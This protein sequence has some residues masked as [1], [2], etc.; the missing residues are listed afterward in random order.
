MRNEILNRE[1]SALMDFD[2]M[3]SPQL[4]SFVNSGET[5]V[6]AFLETYN[7]A[8]S[9]F[10]LSELY[11]RQ[12]GRIEFGSGEADLVAYYNELGETYNQ[13]G[14]E[15]LSLAIADLQEYINS[16]TFPPPGQPA[17]FTEFVAEFKLYFE[18][19]ETKP[20]DTQ[21]L[22]TV[23]NDTVAAV[24]GGEQAT[25]Q[26][27]VD[28]AIELRAVRLSPD[29]GASTN[30]AWWKIVAIAVY[31]GLAATEIWFCILKNKCSK[32]AKAVLKGG[33]TIAALVMKF[34]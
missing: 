16:H 7:D 4:L 30:L 24:S 1:Q 13:K 28:K 25:Y 31:V 20:T 19:L 8:C 34:C 33:Q 2:V 26:F 18:N 23:L 27:L 29:R 10:G 15:L 17:D 5:E 12:K 6:A 9:L 11:Y 21:E 3:S 32:K 22:V 14:V